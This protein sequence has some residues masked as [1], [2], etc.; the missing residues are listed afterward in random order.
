MPIWR[1]HE[2]GVTEALTTDRH[3]EQEGLVR[4]LKK[5]N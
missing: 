5:P 3:F 4:L 1:M 2:R